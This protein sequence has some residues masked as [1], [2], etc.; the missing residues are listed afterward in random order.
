MTKTQQYPQH[1]QCQTPT[2]L[3]LDKQ[4][5][6]FQNIA[7]VWVITILAMYFFTILNERG[8]RITKIIN[9]IFT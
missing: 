5:S 4:G 7:I 8:D 1:N 3:Q 6:R 2:E 9:Q